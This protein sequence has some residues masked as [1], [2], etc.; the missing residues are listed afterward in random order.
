M[1]FLAAWWDV[2]LQFESFESSLDFQIAS[3][4]LSEF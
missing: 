1:F 2:K 4:G 3:V